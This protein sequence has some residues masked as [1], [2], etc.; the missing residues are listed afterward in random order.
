[1]NRKLVSSS[2]IESVG[3]ENGTLEIAFIDGGI[4]QYLNVPEGVYSGLMAASSKGRYLH[5]YIKDHYRTI[6]VA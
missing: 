6:R 5:D 2:N 1:M 4:Y 3:Y